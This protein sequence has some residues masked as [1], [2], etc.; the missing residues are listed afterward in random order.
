MPARVDRDDQ[1]EVMLGGECLLELCSNASN[2]FASARIVQQNQAMLGH[3]GK[4]KLF[5][6]PLFAM[7]AGR[8]ALAALAKR[9]LS[10]LTMDNGRVPSGR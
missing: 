10:A 1:V 3:L 7:G 5:V 9:R 2:V 6:E 8:T 4:P